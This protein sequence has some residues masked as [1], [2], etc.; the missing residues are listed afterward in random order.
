MKIL[1]SHPGTNSESEIQGKFFQLPHV[2]YVIVPVDKEDS[3]NSM[4]FPS[5]SVPHSGSI[6]YLA[7]LSDL[8]TY[9]ETT[10]FLV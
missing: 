1:E 2:P 4:S 8:Q 6:A 9:P 3:L 5:F 10:C 7:L